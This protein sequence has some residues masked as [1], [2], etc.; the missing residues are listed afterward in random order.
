M[1]INSNDTAASAM[2]ASQ[3]RVRVR[4]ML[5]DP[6]MSWPKWREP[7]DGFLHVSTNGITVSAYAEKAARWDQIHF[8][9]YA[10]SGVKRLIRTWVCMTLA[11]AIPI[12]RHNV[13]FA[14]DQSD[15][16]CLRITPGW[17]ADFS[18]FAWFPNKHDVESISLAIERMWENEKA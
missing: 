14:M 17:P 12:A 18:L 6:P 11:Q 10:G 4:F 5:K 9:P 2:P 8:C 16:P 3:P 7:I 13:E 15:Q 1:N